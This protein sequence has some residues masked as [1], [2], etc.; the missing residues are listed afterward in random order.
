M[1]G[2]DDTLLVNTKMNLFL[3]TGWRS[4]TFAPV[5]SEYGHQTVKYSRIRFLSKHSVGYTD[6]CSK[7]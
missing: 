4:H 5:E 7:V 1:H 6:V 2:T 3:I